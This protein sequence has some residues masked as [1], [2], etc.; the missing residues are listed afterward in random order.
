MAGGWVKLYQKL[1]D[2][3]AFFNSTPAQF[4]VFVTVLLLVTWT[5]YKWDVLGHE[6]TLQ[7]GEVFISTR[8]LAYRAGDGVTR[9]VVR[10]ALVRFEKLGIWTLKRT[11]RGHLIHIVNWGKYQS[12]SNEQNPAENPSGTQGEPKQNPSGTQ[13]EPNNK[14]EDKKIRRSEDKKGA[15]PSLLKILNSFESHHQTPE[16]TSALVEWA[17]MRQS[18]GKP[19][20]DKDLQEL[21]RQLMEISGGDIARAIAIV[22]QSTDRK[23]NRFWELKQ[24]PAS[25]QPVRYPKPP[26]ELP[27]G[28][29][30]PKP[31]DFPGD[32]VGFQEAMN[33]WAL[34]HGEENKAIKHRLGEPDEAEKEKILLSM[35]G[36][37]PTGG[38]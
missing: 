32:P 26:R 1:L 12:N 2:D 8:D 31:E 5:P 22:R 4:K 29:P 11:Q 18:N 25:F 7:P 30:P 37:D 14:K 10:K 17:E 6:F 3:P 24:P 35:A 20:I 28:I 15:P 33:G 38:T 9:E 23:W 19:V 16:L 27:K 36:Q 13:G 21:L 34:L